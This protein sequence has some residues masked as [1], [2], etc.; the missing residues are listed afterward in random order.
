VS[1]ELKKSFYKELPFV[2]S[3]IAGLLFYLLSY[4]LSS[5]LK[6]LFINISAAFFAIPLLFLFYELAK[7]FSNRKL[8]KEIHEYLKMQ[9]DREILSVINQ[10]TKIVYD[11]AT[12]DFSL[13]GISNFLNLKEDELRTLVKNHKFLGFQVLK[14]WESGESNL[15]ELLKNNFVLTKAENDQVIS[16]IGVIKS[17]R[18]I[19]QVQKIDD[20]YVE[21]GEISNEYRIV[22]GLDMNERNAEYPDRYL[23]LR[24]LEGDKFM[25]QDFGDFP[26]YKVKNLLK[27]YV[28][29]SKYLDLYSETIYE[30]V[31]DVNIWLNLTG[32]E[33]VVDTKMFRLGVR[34]TSVPSAG[35]DAPTYLNRAM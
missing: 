14:N 7:G 30:L 25:V 20:L 12:Q 10:L 21:N 5:N 18:S 15:Q 33:F 9:V 22:H 6:D 23:L 17:I 11:Y 13:K 3:I 32:H 31:K 27:Y 28:L 29:S 19:E 24:K 16:I 26:K 34:P 2:A 4:Q 35:G 1:R 8:N